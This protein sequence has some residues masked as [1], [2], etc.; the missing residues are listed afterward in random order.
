[1]S[2]TIEAGKRHIR[3]VNQDIQA[4]LAAGDG[5]LSPAKRIPSVLGAALS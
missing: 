5:K 1:M 3:E 2:V 4:A